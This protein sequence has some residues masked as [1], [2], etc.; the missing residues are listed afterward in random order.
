[1]KRSPQLHKQKNMKKMRHQERKAREQKT[2]TRPQPGAKKSTRIRLPEGKPSAKA[3]M[4]TH[5]GARTVQAPVISGS[6]RLVQLPV[7]KMRTGGRS[8]EP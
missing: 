4:T 8:I 5:H 6:N 3:G 7:P 2:S 1:M